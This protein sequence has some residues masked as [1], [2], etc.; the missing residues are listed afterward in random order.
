MALFDVE[1]VE[2]SSRSQDIIKGVSLHIKSGETV[3]IT[4]KSGCGKSTLLKLIAGILV[5]TGGRCLF[6]GHD[7]NTMNNLRNKH[8]RRRCA[9][10]FQDAA[11]WANQDIL[12]NLALPLQI[13]FPSWSA[14]ERL[15]EIEKMCT[16]IKYD[17][18]LS[19]RPADLSMGEQKRIAF[20]RAMICKPDV[21]FL[22]ECTES[23]DSRGAQVIITLLHQFAE[24]GNTI[25]YV[26]HSQSFAKEFAG[27]RYVID[28]G[29]LV[30]A[31]QGG[32][33]DNEV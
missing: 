7:I 13:H 31:E 25:V 16:I 20:A 11:L 15:T 1:A 29:R 3:A 19:L 33:E 22:D 23:L 2:Y 5:P 27:T 4:G 8:F 14:K 28:D 24:A 21:L 18:S 30:D 9:F 12:S 17:R 6:N 10:M 32:A 26:T